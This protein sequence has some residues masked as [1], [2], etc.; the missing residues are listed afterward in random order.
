MKVGSFASTYASESVASECDSPINDVEDSETTKRADSSCCAVTGGRDEA[1]NP[2]HDPWCSPGDRLDGAG[3]AAHRRPTTR[4]SGSPV[5]PDYG[6]TGN[7]FTGDIDWVQIDLGDDSQDHL[8]KPEERL[9]VA[10]ARQ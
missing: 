7:K 4:N 10:M 8:I 1:S 3:G 2:A 6:P 9:T 5:S